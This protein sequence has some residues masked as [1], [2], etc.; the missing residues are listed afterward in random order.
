MLPPLAVLPLPS[1]WLWECLLRA[2]LIHWVKW[3]FI[4]MFYL[5]SKYQDVQVVKGIGDGPPTLF[6]HALYDNNFTFLIF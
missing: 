5:V 4:L 3:Q 1:F 2:R 6:E